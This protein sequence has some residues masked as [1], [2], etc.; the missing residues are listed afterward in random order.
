MM[1][2]VKFLF[3]MRE[4]LLVL[5]RELYTL[6]K[7]DPTQAKAVLR[8]IGDYG[9]LYEAKQHDVDRRLEALRKPDKDGM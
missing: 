7:G 5:C 2:W 8:R 9:A 4:P 1:P 3:V 6:C